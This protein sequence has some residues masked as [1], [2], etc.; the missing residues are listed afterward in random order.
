MAGR[1]GEKWWRDAIRVAIT[2]KLEGDDNGRTKLR[3][4]ADKLV[5]MAL[6]G[7]V[8]ALKEIGDRLDGK[9][10]QEIDVEGKVT[11]EGV[12]VSFVDPAS[13]TPR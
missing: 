1:K 2:E 3:A 6:Q 7:D 8:S 9:A 5:E 4:A 10:T 13:D 12:T 11:V